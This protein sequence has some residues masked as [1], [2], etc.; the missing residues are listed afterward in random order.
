MHAAAAAAAAAADAFAAS[1][2][3]PTAR[4]YNT[5]NV[6]FAKLTNSLVVAVV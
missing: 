2:T 6:D 4:R 1:F 3:L 5:L